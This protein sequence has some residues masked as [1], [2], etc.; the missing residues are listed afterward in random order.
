MRKDCDCLP[1]GVR[2]QSTTVQ[3]QNRSNDQVVQEIRLERYQAFLKKGSVTIYQLPLL[4][5]EHQY[6]INCRLFSPRT[7]STTLQGGAL[8]FRVDGTREA[9]LIIFPHAAIF[10]RRCHH[11]SR[12]SF[13]LDFPSDRAPDPANLTQ[14]RSLLV[15]VLVGIFFVLFVTSRLRPNQTPDTRTIQDFY[16]KTVHGLE[17]KKP[18]AQG[19]IANAVQDQDTDGDVDAEDE[20]LANDLATRLREAADKAKDLANKKAPLKPDSPSEVVGVGNSAAH[21]DSTDHAVGGKKAKKPEEVGD[22]PDPDELL[23]VEAELRSLMRKYPVLIFSKT[24]CPFSKRA[25]GLLLDKYAIEPP[26]FVVEL[27]QHPLGRQLQEYL[28]EKT[29]LTTVPNILVNGV[30]MGGS[31][32]LAEL[33]ANNELIDK[34]VHLGDK[35]VNMK[36]RLPQ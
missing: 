29:G 14:V 23:A 18:P 27:D 31:D 2:T 3:K 32:N 12:D 21:Q 30:S 10:S 15:G 34:M 17:S 20:Q 19:D 36:Q 26:P 28:G 7:V 16:H 13:L 6:C 25:K 1:Y 33:D 11:P 5:Y 24:W 35:K 8:G 4:T 22:E 9:G